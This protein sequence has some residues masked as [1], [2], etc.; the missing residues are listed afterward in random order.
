M[1]L[2]KDGN[3]AVAVLCDGNWK[4]GGYIVHKELKEKEVALKYCKNLIL[5]SQIKLWNKVI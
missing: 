1:K 5:V 2:D 3:N 4:L